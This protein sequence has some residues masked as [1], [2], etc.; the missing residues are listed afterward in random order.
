MKVLLSWLREFAPIEGS[1]DEVAA[2]LTA[3][4]MELESVAEVGR[5]LDGIVVAKVLAVREHPDAD[6]I[7]LVDVDPGDGSSLQIACGASNMA[8]GDLVPLATVGTVMPDGMEISARRMRGEMSNG[9]LCSARELQ[10]GDDH[11]GILILPG[12]LEPGAPV[13]EALGLAEDV[14]F[15][16]DALPNRPDTLSVLGVARDLAAHQKVPFHVPEPAVD[17]EGAPTGELASVE[18]LAPDLCGRFLVRVLSGIELAPSPR[19]MAQ[20]LVAAGMRPINNVVDVSNY[21]MLETGQPNHTYDLARLPG[22]ALRVRWARDGE[23][24]VTLDGVERELR[25]S[26]GVITDAED[27]PV[28]LAGVM[29]GASTEIGEGTTD[30]LLELAWWDPVAVAATSTRLNL[31]SE[32][33]LRFKRGVDPEI[34]PHAARRFAELLAAVTPARLHPG[35]VE[36]RGNLPEPP[37]VRVRTGRVNALLGTSLTRD[38]VAGLLEP[39][40]YRS[41]PVGDDDLD[42]AVPSWRPDSSIEADVVEEVARHHGYDRLPRE[43]PVSPHTGELSPAQRDRRVLR[44]TLM[45]QG[46]DEAMPMPFLA[47][48]DLERCGLPPDGLRLANPLAAEESVLRTS[49]L[50][51]LLD[52]V[53]YNASHRNTGVRLFEVGRVF[54]LGDEGVI[55]DVERSVAAGRVLSGEREHLAAVLAGCEAPAAVELLEVALGA[56]GRR[57]STLHAAEIPGLHPGRAAQ[58]EVRAGGSTSVVGTVGEVDPA[59][60]ARLGIEERVAWLQLDLD[61]LAALPVEVPLHRPVSRLPSTDFDLAFTVPEEVPAADVAA[62]IRE[63]GGPLVAR[64]EL[65]DV[66]RSEQLGEGRRSLAYRIR[67]QPE[68]RTLTDAEVGEL[69]AAAVAAVER[70]HGATLRA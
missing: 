36:A 30:V 35:E 60:L 46:L 42:V 10:L 59:V 43:V 4:G 37:T 48:G 61:A 38:E 28:A 40:G 20:R 44:R 11:S 8:P 45:A 47:P 63:A 15:E 12:D 1:A 25:S 65:F 21:V 26:D 31:P 69:R 50:P 56:V 67:V 23:R 19:W 14:V 16:F 24:L 7:R 54:S 57:V 9:M 55:T 5:G 68:E 49:L 32:A 41:T 64:V 29:G 22:G 18:I 3:L 27:R 33:S 52:A 53:A 58:V 51:G 2:Q 70:T 62:T 39:I 6:R 13:R 66:F 17:T 34:A